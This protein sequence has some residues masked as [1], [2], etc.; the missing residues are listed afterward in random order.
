MWLCVWSRGKG[1]SRFKA[2][3]KI[4]AVACPAQCTSHTGMENSLWKGPQ[5]VCSP[6][7][8][9]KQGQLWAQ[10]RLL[11]AISSQGLKHFPSGDGPASLHNLFQCPT[12][13]M[14]KKSI[15][16]SSLNFSCVRCRPIISYCPTRHSCEEPGS[17]SL[18]TDSWAVGLWL[19]PPTPSVLWGEPAPQHLLTGQVLPPW[20]SHWS[21]AE[22]T[23]AGWCLPCDILPSKDDCTLISILLQFM[24]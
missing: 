12:V 20:A 10:T 1:M 7:H 23:P 3:V 21:S 2:E 11:R 15:L 8:C 17:S 5:E 24:C 13:L 14:G 22:F 4:I 16:L 19:D 18:M 6:I 9:A